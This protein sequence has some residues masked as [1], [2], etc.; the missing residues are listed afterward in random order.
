MTPNKQGLKQNIPSAIAHKKSLPEGFLTGLE[1]FAPLISAMAASSNALGGPKQIKELLAKIDP[2]AAA[3]KDSLQEGDMHVVTAT[4]H[5]QTSHGIYLESFELSHPAN[6]SLAIEEIVEYPSMGTPKMGPATLPY[7]LIPNSE[8]IY[9]FKLPVMA[10]K[11]FLKAPYASVS[12][13]YS[14]LDEKSIRKVEIVF[15]LRMMRAKA[16]K[17]N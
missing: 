6:G 1:A 3:I 16:V 8:K 10:E 13:S 15:R 9:K 17:A 5:N 12:L 2:V 7:L 4:F 14:K 11:A